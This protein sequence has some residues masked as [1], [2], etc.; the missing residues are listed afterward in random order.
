MNIGTLRRLISQLPSR[1]ANNAL[2]KLRGAA[3]WS[4]ADLKELRILGGEFTE[5]SL[6][7]IADLIATSG[8][9]LREL[10]ALSRS[11]PN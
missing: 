10:K 2:S 1:T 4:E 8:E 7:R 6:N 11:I 9:Y 3:L 5:L